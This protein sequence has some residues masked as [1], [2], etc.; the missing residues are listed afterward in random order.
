MAVMMAVLMKCAMNCPGCMRLALEPALL[1]YRHP[2]VKRFLLVTLGITGLYLG[3]N[4]L[5]LA[6]TP[7]LSALFDARSASAWE[8]EAAD[9]REASRD[10]DGRLPP[11]T[12]LSAYR[13]GFHVGYC[14]NLLGS[15]ALSAPERQEQMRQI[16][17][18]RI[19]AID[20]LGQALGVGAVSLLPVSNADEFARVPS[21]L[22][23]DELGLAAR[24]EAVTSQRHRHLLLLGVHAGVAMALADATGG[25]MHN[26]I[27]DYIGRH[28]TLA[29]VPPS[30]WEPVAREAS[31]ATSKDRLEAYR[32]SLTALE[33]AVVQLAPLR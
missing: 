26:R 19:Q 8:R 18:P 27:R 7:A 5:W 28:A 15:M 10:A 16:L 17:A 21:R 4:A 13:L 29:G 23:A 22:E 2:R 14:T 25:E 1:C 6:L 32:A 31:G 30:A 9:V 33:T 20:T 11:E 12:R 24:L 3:L